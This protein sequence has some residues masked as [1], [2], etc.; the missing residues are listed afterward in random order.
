MDVPAVVGEA[1]QRSS[2]SASSTPRRAR[3]KTTQGGGSGR[4]PVTTIMK[5]LPRA[6]Q[7]RGP[8]PSHRGQGSVDV[9]I[10]VHGPSPSHWGQGSVDVPIEVHHHQALHVH[11]DRTQ[12]VT[13]GVDPVEYGRMVGEAQ[14]L[15]DESKSRADHFEGLSQEIYS[16]ACQQVQQLMTIAQQLHQSCIEKDESL[17][18]LSFEVQ[19]VKVQLEEQVSLN[20]DLMTQFE[21]AKSQTQRL[22]GHK[23]SE[24]S[25]L[26]SE[27]S[28]LSS[29]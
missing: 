14:R 26:M 17:R 18:K 29:A 20:H 23:D 13:M 5:S 19:M 12:T 15:L 21:S 2:R 22:L 1:S 4:K 6:S 10:E 3:S 8:S 16:Q 24:I 9:P 27:V 25:R 7:S 28:D 11:D